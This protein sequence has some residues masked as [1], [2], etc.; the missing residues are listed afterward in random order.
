[1]KNLIILFIFIF[2]V[3]DASAQSDEQMLRDIY[4]EQLGNS[5]GYENLKYL[6]KEIGNRINGSPQLSA[7]IEFARQLMI[8]YQFDTVYL[9]PVMVPNWKRGEKET[10]KIVNSL[11]LGNKMLHCISFGN[12]IGTGTDGLSG[13]LAEVKSLDALKR[14]DKDQIQGKIVFV[15]KTIDPSKF[16]I[17]SEYAKN[18]GIRQNGANIA[19]EKGAIAIIVRSLSTGIDQYAHTG[20]TSYSD[21]NKKIPALAIGNEEADMLSA[22][23]L[24]EPETELYIETYC[25]TYEDVLSYNL[26]GEIRGTVFPNDIIVVGGHIDSWDF[27]EGAHDDGAGCVQSIEVGRTFKALKIEPKHTIRIILWVDEE[28]RASGAKEYAKQSKEK[29]TKHIAAIESDLGGFLPLGFYIDTDNEVALK[30]VHSWKEYFQPYEMFQFVEGLAGGVDIEPLKNDDILLMTLKTNLQ[31]YTTIYHSE[32]DVFEIVDRRELALGAAA[33][34]SIVY[35][36]DKYA[37]E[38]NGHNMQ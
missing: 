36:I 3:Y 33:I 1:M 4:E 34:I 7:A 11:S 37:L 28:N 15:N 26:I 31:Q 38:L 12:S 17:V 24:K 30:Q 18:I 23:L 6:S 9:Q 8:N 10:V 29:K 32:R 35:L 5:S 14:I 21:P 2:C 13:E 25:K 19:A 22:L 27:G 16:D 20:N